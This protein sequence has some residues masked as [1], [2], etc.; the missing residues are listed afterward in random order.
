MKNILFRY[1]VFGMTRCCTV[2]TDQLMDA[3]AEVESNRGATSAN[4]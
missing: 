3:I 1:M 4:V 2:T